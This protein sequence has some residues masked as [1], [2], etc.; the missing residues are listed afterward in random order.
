MQVY[1]VGGAVRDEL[2]GLAVTERDW[3]VVGASPEQMESQGYK[4]VGKDFPV[5]LHPQSKEEY[6]LAR[7]ERKKG[8]GYHG[9]EV[10]A[11]PEVS[12]EEDLRRRD[13]TIN[14]IAKSDTGEIIDPY[15]GQADLKNKVLRHVSDAFAE[16]PLRVI[17]VARFVSRFH[18]LGFSIAKETQQ[19]M[20]HI[21]ASRE[22]H[23]LSPERIW[24][25][26]HKALSMPSPEQFFLVLHSVGA[27]SQTHPS[28]SDEFAD[29]NSRHLALTALNSATSNEDDACVR[30]A[31]FLGG[32]YYKNL[33]DSDQD[34]QVLCEKLILPKACKEL[35]LLTA[36]KL[37]KCQNVFELDEVELLRLLR[38]M[39]VKRK[40][41]RFAALLRIFSIV[42][43]SVHRSE[44][45]SAKADADYPQADFLLQAANTIENIDI[46]VWIREKISHEELAN[47]IQ[48]AQQELL[49]KLILENKF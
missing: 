7:T 37:N 44:N 40:P 41:E 43:K 12:L 28:I 47:N 27:L 15:D 36:S 3:V 21:V 1:L 32:L 39:D 30:F 6:A 34:I 38:S 25:E 45:R 24:Q 18:M 17:R 35:L 49:K 42:H 5:F 22:I 20:R 19:L 2:L 29:Q 14:A 26:T 16:D 31:T 10:H 33:E 48:H 9:F 4:A 23:E 13:L 8:R 46:E 11:S